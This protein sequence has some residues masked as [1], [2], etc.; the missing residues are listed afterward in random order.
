LL[1]SDLNDYDNKNNENQNKDSLASLLKNSNNNGSDGNKN[2]SKAFG[3]GNNSSDFGLKVDDF[4]KSFGKVSLKFK[5]ISSV[6]FL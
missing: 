4:N 2:L 6:L 5:E 3:A 1:N